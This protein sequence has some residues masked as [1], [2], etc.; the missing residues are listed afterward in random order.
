MN[1]IGPEIDVI[2]FAVT[3]AEK[4]N[5]W[6]KQELGDRPKPFAGEWPSAVLVNHSDQ[7]IATRHSREL[8]ANSPQRK[9]ESTVQHTGS[10]IW[11]HG[12][13]LGV[14]SDLKGARYGETLQAAGRTTRILNR[15]R[16]FAPI[17]SKPTPLPSDVS[18]REARLAA[19]QL[20]M[21]FGSSHAK[22]ELSTLLGIGTFYFA[23]THSA[24]KASGPNSSKYA[25]DG[26]SAGCP[27]QT[28]AKIVAKVPSR[29]NKRSFQV[30]ESKDGTE[31][32]SLPPQ[33]GP[34]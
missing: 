1:R 28:V 27:T 9:K 32:G 5:G 23:L 21:A 33:T 22:P 6:L 4:S 17:L 10:P 20:T 12:L 13:G 15:P 29:F 16:D 19:S 24:R 7:I 18:R 3:H 14:G 34:V 11:M 8:V 25:N 2:A 30:V 31:G 26:L